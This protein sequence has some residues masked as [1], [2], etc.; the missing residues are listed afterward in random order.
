MYNIFNGAKYFCS[1]GHKIIYYLCQLEISNGL[2][3]TFDT[4]WFNNSIV[5]FYRN[6]RRQNWK[7]SYF[8]R[9]FCSKDNYK[10]VKFRGICLKQ[11][12]VSFLYK[13]IINLYITNKLDTWLK[14]VKTDITIG[15]CLNL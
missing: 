11:D 7:S 6:I 15:N 5:G 14:D 4:V 1:V 3:M 13:N 8:R 12:S 10:E 2:V 9:Q